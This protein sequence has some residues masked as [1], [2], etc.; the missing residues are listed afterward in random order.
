[1]DHG[2][3]LAFDLFL[4]TLRELGMV[5]TFECVAE[6]VRGLQSLNY[7]LSGPLYQKSADAWFKP[8]FGHLFAIF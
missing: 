4:Y 6:F 2:P 7:F 3:H 1:M 5:F 8:L